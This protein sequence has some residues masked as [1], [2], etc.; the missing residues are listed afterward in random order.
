MRTPDKGEC[1]EA[2]KRPGEAS[3]PSYTYALWKRKRREE[4]KKRIERK[5]FVDKK[6]KGWDVVRRR[7][8]QSQEANT[9]LK[10]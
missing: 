9:D 7:L 8:K 1:T 5:Y 3:H 6:H 2:S 10:K 4:E